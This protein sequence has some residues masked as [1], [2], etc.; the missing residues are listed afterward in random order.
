MYAYLSFQFPLFDQKRTE[1]VKAF[2]IT[3][4][5]RMLIS[6]FKLKEAAWKF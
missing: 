1:L 3:N 6:P 4:N 2:C 5:A